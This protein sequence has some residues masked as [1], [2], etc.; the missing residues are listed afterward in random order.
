MLMRLL[1]CSAVSDTLDPSVME[2]I[3]PLASEGQRVLR[4]R[5]IAQDYTLEDALRRC[6]HPKNRPL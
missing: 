4:E 1:A 2:Q 6:S 5:A 3:Y